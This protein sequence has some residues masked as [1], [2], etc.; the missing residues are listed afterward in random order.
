MANLARRTDHVRQLITFRPRGHWYF[1]DS[2]TPS[3]FRGDLSKIFTKYFVQKRGGR[4]SHLIY[5][6]EGIQYDNTGIQRLHEYKMLRGG[7]L[8]YSDRYLLNL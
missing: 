6:W 8:S 1:E 7:S 4:G 5:H 3:L 2:P